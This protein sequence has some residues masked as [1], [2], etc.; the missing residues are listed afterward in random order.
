MRHK[1]RKTL[2][3]LYRLPLASN[4]QEYFMNPLSSLIPVT[5][6]IDDLE[7]L[8]SGVIHLENKSELKIKISTLSITFKFISDDGEIRYIGRTEGNDLF[9]DLYNHNN[10]LGE[11]ALTPLNFGVINNRKAYITYFT[12]T[13]VVE[14]QS[15]RFEYVVYLGANNG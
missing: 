6:E 5:V 7:V 3:S 9:I 2:H 15:R 1:R 13:L 4:Q 11:G 12:N 8:H 14:K 10:V